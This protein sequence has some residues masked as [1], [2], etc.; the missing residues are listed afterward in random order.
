MVVTDGGRAYCRDSRQTSSLRG[1]AAADAQAGGC[2]PATV[3]ASAGFCSPRVAGAAA[4]GGST[5]ITVTA[6]G[7]AQT[8]GLQPAPPRY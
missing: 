6:P 2:R 7:R 5:P 8:S 1:T 4:A 3:K